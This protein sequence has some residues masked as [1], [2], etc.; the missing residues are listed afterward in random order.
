MPSAMSSPRGYFTEE[1][2]EGMGSVQE[3]RDKLDS[4]FGLLDRPRRS[5]KMV[6]ST[7]EVVKSSDQQLYALSRCRVLL[8]TETK[9]I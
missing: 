8:K 3:H 6:L 9:R 2:R 1:V 7:T 5:S 4:T